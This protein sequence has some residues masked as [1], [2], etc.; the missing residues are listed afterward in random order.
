M[1]RP[2][3]LKR[4]ELTTKDMSVLREGLS[5][6]QQHTKTA[7]EIRDYG[8]NHRVGLSWGN[9]EDRDLC[10]FQLHIDSKT[11][12][13]SW[14]ELRD[15]DMAGFFRREGNH[16]DYYRLKFLEGPKV[17][18]TTDLNEEAINDRIVQINIEDAEIYVD[19]YEMLRW[20]RFV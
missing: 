4:G 14:G 10:P 17:V 3:E 13:L 20:L 18:I 19:W 11:Y 12:T 6:K 5:T 16:P 7:A 9:K 2:P 1:A 8:L 15:M